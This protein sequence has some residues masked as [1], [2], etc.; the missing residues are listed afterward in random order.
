MP[1]ALFFHETSHPPS[2]YISPSILGGAH[3]TTFPPETQFPSVENVGFHV[4]FGLFF[5]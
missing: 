1:C 3:A 4:L 2:I 5:L